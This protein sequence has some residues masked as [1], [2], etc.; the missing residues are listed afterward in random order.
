MR[1]LV[2]ALLVVCVATGLLYVS[3][4]WPYPLWTGQ[5][6]LGQAGWP[7][8]GGLLMQ[9]LRG[10]QFVQFELLIWVLGSFFVLSLTEKLAHRI[11]GASSD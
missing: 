7:P 10:T 1:R 9:W 3:R 8:R 11:R 4:F 2:S 6:W 5:S